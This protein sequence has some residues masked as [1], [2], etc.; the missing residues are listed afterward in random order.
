M[1]AFLS[2]LGEVLND[3]CGW[4]RCNLHVYTSYFWCLIKFVGRFY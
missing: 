3:F 4:L 2:E 1:I